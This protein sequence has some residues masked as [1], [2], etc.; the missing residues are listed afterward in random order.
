MRKNSAA[1]AADKEEQENADKLMRDIKAFLQ[2]KGAVIAEDEA[3]EEEDSD[4][5]QE[6][7]GIIM[8]SM[9]GPQ[10][11]ILNG[12]QD[13]STKWSSDEDDVEEMKNPD[14]KKSSSRKNVHFRDER[15]SFSP[16]RIPRDS[17]SHLIWSIF[18][19]ERQERE[20]KNKSRAKS[21]DRA[22]MSRVKSQHANVEAEF[23][24][25]LLNAKMAELQK[26]IERYQKENASLS[27][28]KRKL[29]FDRKQ[30]AKEVQEFEALKETEKK[31]MEEEKK[32]VRRDKTLL[33]KELRTKT[34]KVDQKTTEE[35]EELQTKVFIL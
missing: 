34:V 15:M 35:M 19:K 21:A 31:K 18:A 9:H 12:L 29:Q 14:N 6:D 25:T 16:P 2:N 23:E 26:E 28:G 24:A 11:V 22:P 27:S 10:Q 8:D 4:T 1:A 3:S 20:R 32:R 7:D 5:I 17:A 33:E 30:L 13:H